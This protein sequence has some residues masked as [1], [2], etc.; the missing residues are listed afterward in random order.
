[1]VA[2]ESWSRSP[3]SRLLVK[4]FD[5]AHNVHSDLTAVLRNLFADLQAIHA[6]PLVLAPPGTFW[7]A[8]LRALEAESAV[9]ICQK[10][11][12]REVY[13]RAAHHLSQ[14]V[15]G[16]LVLPHDTPTATIRP[17]DTR[18][19]V[20]L[21]LPSSLT[22]LHDYLSLFAST[23]P[24]SLSLLLLTDTTPLERYVLR[25]PAVY[26]THWSQALGLHPSN[27]QV[28]QQ[29]LLC[30]AAELALQA[31]EHYVKQPGMAQ[32]IEQL[33]AAQAL[34]RRTASGDWITTR[35]QVHRRV[36]LRAYETPFAVVHQL[37][38]QLLTRVRPGQAFR[39]Y[40][41]GA[42]F[43]H[44]QQ[45]FHVEQ[46]LTDR[47]RILVRSQRIRSATR[48]IITTH[49]AER[50]LEASL[51]TETFRLSTGGLSIIDTLHAYERLDPQTYRRT[52]VH[53]L[54]AHRRQLHTQGTW[55]DF[56]MP[57]ASWH[58]S[59]QTAVHTFTHAIL[60]GL[61]LLW[62]DDDMPNAS[63]LLDSENSENVP[64]VVVF[65]ES[66]GGNGVSAFLYHTHTPD[67]A[68]RTTNTVT[69]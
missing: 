36:R 20:F 46:V 68:P 13:Q 50:R 1:M 16:A 56:L 24:H 17:I 49:I 3:Q 57:A 14:G 18:S 21:G 2:G 30:A 54:P 31:G 32:L 52:S 59:A 48:G 35:R 51:S 11:V 15:Y 53:G 26:Q 19:I 25:Y 65:D 45:P 44:D 33:A 38:G 67:I 5:N 66:A 29:H 27:P 10:P 40:F 37:D 39:D 62:L 63:V 7:D 69:V 47:R 64:G 34:V 28:A 6:P 9:T 23:Q 8:P 12:S 61:P 43:T 55:L 22:L 58:V 60:A 42:S 4:A 41:E